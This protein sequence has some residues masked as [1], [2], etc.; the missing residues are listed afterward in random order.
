MGLAL[1][2]AGQV[3]WNGRP[4]DV[5]VRRR[6][7][8]M[9][10]ERGLYPKM[11]VGEQLTYFAR[12]HGLD[13][14][15]AARAAASWAERLGLG[16]RR[17]DRVEKLSLGNQQRVQLAAALV[18][19]PDV[20]ILDEPFSGLD[21]VG[22]D[23][24]AEALLEQC[25]RGVP[26]VFSSHQLDLVERLCDAVGILARGKIVASGTVA[27]LRSSA[28]G[29]QLRVVAPDAPPGWAAGLPG[30][31]VVSE[32][33]GDTVLELG[34]GGDDQQVLATALTTGRVAHFA[35]REPTLVELFRDAVTD[36]REVAA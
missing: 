1:A 11:R 34:P 12:L 10:E 32:Q 6:V 5:G 22:V 15:P 16:E 27:G 14:A 24:L 9:P 13:A 29:R 19:E 36:V 30:V 18:S 28:V 17:G 20:L 2:D 7:G 4:V 25:R 3:R 31:R 35:W 21:P 23:S 26:V 8:Y 33:R